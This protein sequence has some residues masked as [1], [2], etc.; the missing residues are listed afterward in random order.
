MNVVLVSLI[1]FCDSH[2]PTFSIY[3]SQFK[4]Y[5]VP[6]P[7]CHFTFVSIK[8]SRFKY[9]HQMVSVGP[10]TPY[11]L[12]I[13]YIYVCMSICFHQI[14]CVAGFWCP[15]LF[16]MARAACGAGASSP[17][18]WYRKSFPFFMFFPLCFCFRCLNSPLTNDW[19]PYPLCQLNASFVAQVFV[20]PCFCIII[21][22]FLGPLWFSTHSQKLARG[23]W[24]SAMRSRFCKQN[25]GCTYLFWQENM[26][27]PKGLCKHKTLKAMKGHL[28]FPS[29]KSLVMY[30][31]VQFFFSQTNPQVL[32]LS[33]VQAFDFRSRQHDAKWAKWAETWAK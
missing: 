26:S 31:P 32:W 19:S 18:F 16:R 12:Y 30:T 2:V 14:I 29:N 13:I 9:L 21:Y 27:W 24:K 6:S 3:H 7:L 8:W 10:F 17:A 33:T 15:P 5:H 11:L 20:L 4:I 22:F 25:A 23:N 1:F 28:R